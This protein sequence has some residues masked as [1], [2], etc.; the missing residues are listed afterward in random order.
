M[1]RTRRSLLPIDWLLLDRL[2]TMRTKRARTSASQRSSNQKFAFH[3]SPQATQSLSNTLILIS[4][5]LI[6]ML[7]SVS[8]MYLIIFIDSN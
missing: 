7:L 4:A 5:L 1:S 6:L 2:I 3:L 8:H